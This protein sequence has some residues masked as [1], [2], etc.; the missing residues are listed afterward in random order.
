MS[1]KRSHS[2]DG[3]D[4]EDTPFLL[5]ATISQLLILALESCLAGHREWEKDLDEFMNSA[6][7]EARSGVQPFGTSLCTCQRRWFAP[8]MTR[9]RKLLSAAH[10]PSCIVS[11]RAHSDP[12][13]SSS[14][15]HQTNS[16]CS[17]DSQAPY[18]EVP[19]LRP[20]L[21]PPR[22]AA[23]SSPCPLRLPGTLRPPRGGLGE[24]LG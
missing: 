18:R 11:Q 15:A 21:P 4:T 1:L 17:H 22:V 20:P 16:P 3:R 24:A 12:D 23:Q 7:D 10:R 8:L 2:I 5:T 14:S 19:S 13:P 9:S 6:L